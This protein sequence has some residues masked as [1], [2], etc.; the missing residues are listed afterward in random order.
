MK[1]KNVFSVVFLFI[2]AKILPQNI[3]SDSLGLNLKEVII[4]ATRT[5]RELSSLPLPVTLVDQEIISSSGVVRLDEILIEQ[6]GV[7]IV[8]DESGFEGIQMQGI[9]SDYILILIDGVP[10]IGRKAGNFDLSR[11]AIGNIK[12]IEIVKGP[13]SSLFG[14][15]ALGGVINIITE[16][17]KTKKLNGNFSYRF[18]SFNQ[19][20]INTNIKQNSGKFKFNFFFNR[21]SSDGYQVDSESDPRTF[22]PFKN[23]TLHGKISN[24]FSK[25]L[26]GLFSFR[27]YDNEQLSMLI[28]NEEDF[29]GETQENDMNIHLKFDQNV[30]KKFNIDYELYFT[31]YNADE[32]IQSLLTENIL[33][34]NFFNQKLLRPEIRGNLKLKSKSNFSGG[35]GYQYEELSRTFFDDNINFSSQY[36]FIQGD[37]YLADKLNLIAGSRFDNH[38][39]YK[40]QLSPKLAFYYKANKSLALK[41]SVGF[42]FK[43][44][45]FRQL[46]FNFTNSSVGYTV[47]G[48]NVALDKL[49]ELIY[50]NQIQDVVIPRNELINSLDAESSIGYNLGISI[51]EPKWKL[52]LNFFRND[53]KNLIDTRIIARKNNGQNVFSY[54]NFDQIFTTGLELNFNHR[55][56]EKLNINGGY[57]L[58]YAFDKVKIQQINSGEIY[59]RET[60]SNKTVELSNKDYFGLVNRSR[61]LGNLKFFYSFTKSKLKVNLRFIYRSKY[62]EFDTN[63]NGL[64]DSY[65]TS[66]INGYL[67]TNISAIKDLSKKIDFQ[68]GLSNNLIDYTDANTPKIPGALG[69]LKLTYKT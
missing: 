65:D 2:S 45:A 31:S 66:F 54:V 26:T 14:S 17:P 1:F 61:H 10:L 63:G 68:L 22:Y 37:F 25:K 67:T 32:L 58:L 51:D 36:F 16:E 35:I 55:I 4:S 29:E 69:F 57:Q 30:S 12:Q 8:A 43:S 9:S 27:F 13:S 47:L 19:Q 42:G 59:A 34:D 20:D 44:P 62:A 3:S 24:D 53:I 6:T 23:Y 21:L 18:G 40:S 28:L 39:E 49:D 50:Q 64:V 38:S 46:Y 52:D 5:P 11:M 48:Y 41:A 15:E 56:T 7:N 33:N 60:T